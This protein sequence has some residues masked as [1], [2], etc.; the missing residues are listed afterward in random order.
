MSQAANIKDCIAKQKLIPLFYT[1]DPVT[2][3]S[4]LDSLYDGGVRVI[5]FTHRGNNALQVFREMVAVKEDRFP[6]MKLLT[7][8]IFSPEQA[9]LYMEAGADGLVSPCY[10]PELAAFANESETFWIPGC[11]TPTEINMAAST[12]S[13]WIKLFPGNTIG[14][15][16]VKA[17]KPVF[18]SLH[19]MVTGGVEL[20]LINLKRWF[21]AGASAAGL[22]SNWISTDIIKSAAMDSLAAN[23]RMAMD[24]VN[25]LN[26]P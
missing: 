1:A 22:G 3:T 20:D 4:I 15:D 9:E 19:F 2:A 12:G 6:E 8:T 7:G 23:T 5:E 14:P 24:L 18:P 10:N 17:I 11:M 13:E 26:Q 21:N 25:Q 16:F